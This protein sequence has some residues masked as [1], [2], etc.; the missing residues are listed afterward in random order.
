MVLFKLTGNEK[1]QHRLGVWHGQG[2]KIYDSVQCNIQDDI[3]KSDVYKNVVTILSKA[4]AEKI[5]TKKD[6]ATPKRY[7]ISMN[8]S[9]LGGMPTA[10]RREMCKFH[11]IDYKSM[12]KAE[13]IEA[14]LNL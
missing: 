3:L 1:D 13:E 9:V 7:S 14:L 4:E 6:I 5:D 10:M 12:N 8:E 2:G 11:G